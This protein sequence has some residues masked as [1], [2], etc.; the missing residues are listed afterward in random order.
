MR[1]IVITPSKNVD[2][3]HYLANYMLK[4]G[5]PTLH[6]RKT[7]FSREDLVNYIDQFPEEHQ[8]KMVLHSHHNILLDY[9]LKGIHMNRRHKRK[10]FKSWL[11]QTLIG[12]RMNKKIT[13]SSS[14]KSLSSMADNYDT[15]EYIML[16]PIF[17]D[18][19]GHSPGFSPALLQQ[20][21]V[22]YPGKIVA[23][24]GV[25]ADSIEKARDMGFSGIAFHNYLWNSEDVIKKFD[26]IMN[27]FQKLGITIS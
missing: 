7:G 19:N 21:L 24:G 5:L 3:E 2:N 10:Q 27:R 16:A 26:E 18:S 12:F 20:V 25:N 13:I 4:N 1:F 6:L 8:N 22:N 9:D 15:Y 14:S 23:R 17:S 11:T